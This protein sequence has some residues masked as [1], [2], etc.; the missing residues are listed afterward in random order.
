MDALRPSY[1]APT[2]DG[3]P[4]APGTPGQAQPVPNLYAQ[5]KPLGLVHT[6]QQPA[7]AYASPLQPP[8]TVPHAAPAPAAQDA[9]LDEQQI[10]N[11]RTMLAHI[12]PD[13]T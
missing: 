8:S 11:L 12:A 4:S 6:A 10:E 3:E 7:T 2:S 1:A 9:G 5:R 13:R